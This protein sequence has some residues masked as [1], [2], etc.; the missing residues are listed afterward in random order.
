MVSD[1]DED[2]A[3]RDA[4]IDWDKD[5][6]GR[7]RARG[8]EGADAASAATCTMSFVDFNDSM[9]E[10]VDLWSEDVAE[11]EYCKFL[12]TV[13]EAVAKDLDVERLKFKEVKDIQLLG[14]FAEGR[15]STSSSTSSSDDGGGGGGDDDDDDDDK[16]EMS[17]VRPAAL[18]DGPVA[19][20][21]GS[22][23][24]RW[25]GKRRS[26]IRGNE[27]SSNSTRASERLDRNCD[28]ASS[29]LL[30]TSE[31]HA[32]GAIRL[33]GEIGRPSFSCG[34]AASEAVETRVAGITPTAD[35]D[36][37]AP[38]FAARP[39]SVQTTARIYQTHLPATKLELAVVP[40]APSGSKDLV[41]AIDQGGRRACGGVAQEPIKTKD[42]IRGT[43]KEQIKTKKAKQKEK[44][45][46]E[47]PR[48]A[49]KIPAP[50]AAEVVGPVRLT[51]LRVVTPLKLKVQREVPTSARR[52]SSAGLQGD[53]QHGVEG[54]LLGSEGGAPRIAKALFGPVHH[55]AGVE[56]S[57]L[58][59]RLPAANGKMRRWR[60]PPRQRPCTPFEAAVCGVA[61]A[62]IFRQAVIEVLE[63]ALISGSCAKDEIAAK[64]SPQRPRRRSSVSAKRTPK[65]PLAQIKARPPNSGFPRY[66]FGELSKLCPRT[67]VYPSAVS[68]LHRDF[69]P[70][71][72]R[73]HKLN[74]VDTDT[75]WDG[76]CAHRH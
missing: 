19:D 31:G 26:T 54:A 47:P 46:I 13:M 61:G 8:E 36:T 7:K 2:V 21:I 4:R 65:Q 45:V 42:Q 63:P 34:D 18:G 15:S 37:T 23:S 62:E 33:T 64:P 56:R 39:G 29:E 40:E 28:G 51:K 17:I 24:R 32:Q 60:P 74:L 50:S 57:R 49:P 43:A 68:V 22:D 71:T 27:S 73:T 58:L 76:S 12:Q 75:F 14:R 52:K 48:A 6:I 69:I 38:S 44:G 59:P 5:I 55:G 72:P 41:R 35:S 11:A 3:Y 1:F 25:R 53:A 70:R 30:L 10:L 67:C 20:A 16:I 66:R 9:F